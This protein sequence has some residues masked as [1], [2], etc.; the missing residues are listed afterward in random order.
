[1][2]FTKQRGYNGKKAKVTY[3]F[4]DLRLCM[5]MPLRGW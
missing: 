3:F 2:E 4:L 5:T 1:M